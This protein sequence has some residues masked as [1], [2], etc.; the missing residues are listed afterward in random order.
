MSRHVLVAGGAGYVGSHAC[1]TLAQAGYVP[2]AYDNMIY[3]HEWA[4]RWGPLE[5]GDILDSQRLDEVFRRY[6]PEAVLHFAAFA[7]VGE[8]VGDPGKYY[9]NNVAGT[10]VLLETMRQHGVGRIVFSSTCST[11]GIPQQVPIPESHPQNPINPYGASKL[12]VERILEDFDRAHRVKS[13]CLRYFNAAGADPDCEIG[14]Y[15]DPETH[16]IPLVLYAAAGRRPSVAIYGDDYPTADGTCIRDYV[17]VSDLAEAHVA[18]LQV[19][20]Q[21]GGSDRFN[22]G[23]GRGSSV[24]EVVDTGRRVT[25]RTIATEVVTRRAGD[26]AELV[27]DASRAVR[28]L[29]WHPR[30]ADLESQVLHAWNWLTR[31]NPIS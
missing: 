25:G 30:H 6:R 27:A 21:G 11:Y 10:L 24:R 28:A 16:L 9:R 7:Y 1:K 8:S 5:R 12:M 4:V 20:E 17:H 23:T 22:L 26:P 14:E 13:I 3:G 19:L 31:K 29:G 15:H 2:I 18:A